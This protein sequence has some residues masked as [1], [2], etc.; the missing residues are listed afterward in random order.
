MCVS[1]VMKKKKVGLEKSFFFVCV[2]HNNLKI[3][4]CDL[5]EHQN[6]KS[7]LFAIDA[8]VRESECY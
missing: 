7:L 3:D 6:R 5:Q 1:S 8:S 4:G 2:C